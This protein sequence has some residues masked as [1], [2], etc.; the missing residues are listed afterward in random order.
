MHRTKF[1]Y[2]LEGGM[3]GHGKVG[4]EEPLI[5]FPTPASFMVCHCNGCCIENFSSEG[6]GGD[7]S[8]WLSRKM[9]YTERHEQHRK[10]VL[11]V[12]EKQRNL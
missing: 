2:L 5:S 4:E 7:F 11:T 9:P 6:G 8:Y 12:F 1:N 10:I 3:Q